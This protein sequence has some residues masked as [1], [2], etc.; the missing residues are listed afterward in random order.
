MA[1]LNFSLACKRLPEQVGQSQ[2]NLQALQDIIDSISTDVILYDD[3]RIIRSANKTAEQL[4][5]YAPSKLIGK[6]L[7]QLIIPDRERTLGI[8]RDNSQFVAKI[9]TQTLFVM[10]EKIGLCTVVD[11][12]EQEHKEHALRQ[13]AFYD[14]LTGLPNR[15]LLMER[16]QQE[17][18]RSK[19]EAKFLVVMFADLDSFKPVNDNLGHAAGDRLL[20]QVSR[21]FQR[22]CRE[23]DTVAH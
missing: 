22:C 20:K 16:L 15:I 11:V 3:N 7:N 8:K 17:L 23:I 21:N 19:R 18:L 13:L 5:G 6:P 14:A 12:S 9:N 2:N 10:N 1:L 4:L